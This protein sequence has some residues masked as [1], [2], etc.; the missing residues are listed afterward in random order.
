MADAQHGRIS[1]NPE[2]VRDVVLCCYD[3]NLLVSIS[4]FH[5]IGV[6]KC[7]EKGTASKGASTR[8]LNS[9]AGR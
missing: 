2:R 5:S 8:E 1:A 9:L 3:I 7:Q 6:L 4:K